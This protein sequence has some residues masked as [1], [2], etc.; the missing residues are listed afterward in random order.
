MGPRLK[1]TS[2]CIHT[3]CPNI[4]YSS[5]C[6]LCHP[7]LATLQGRPTSL[8]WPAIEY[9]SQWTFDS[10]NSLLCRISKGDAMMP[11][12]VDHSGQNRLL[13]YAP[14]QP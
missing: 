1:T 5:G 3:N 8:L 10:H 7:Q 12:S 4:F 13:L 9:S 14:Q 2:L 11:E 6:D